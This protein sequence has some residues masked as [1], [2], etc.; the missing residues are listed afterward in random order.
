[1]LAAEAAQQKQPLL[2]LGE[3]RRIRPHVRGVPAEIARDVLDR[4]LGAREP[5]ERRRQLWI[6]RRQR[7]QLARHR[8]DQTHDRPLLRVQDLFTARGG[9]EELLRALE[10]LALDPQLLVLARLQRRRL[11]L[12]ELE[13]EQVLALGTRARVGIERRQ[14]RRGLGQRAVRRHHVGAQALVLGERVEDR[15]LALGVGQRLLVVLRSDVDQT[16]DGIAEIARG[17]EPARQVDAPSP[18][19]RDGAAHEEPGLVALLA[20]PLGLEPRAQLGGARRGQV[21]D[22]L[23]PS[24]VAAGPDQVGAGAAAA[25]Q[26]QRLDDDA[27]AGAG[28][29]GDHGETGP[30]LQLEL[31]DQ[32]EA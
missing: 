1:M 20:S 29:A 28:L 22:G 16:G 21:D 11:Q 9:A 5:L 3:P 4:G 19:A 7:R 32:R 27:L 8:A 26:A 23:D 15:H 31:V 6:E 24:L 14:R 17:R 30:Q 2:D 25:Q 12:A 18:G 10:P 13:L